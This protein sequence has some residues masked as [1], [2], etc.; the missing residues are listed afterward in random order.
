VKSERSDVYWV[1]GAAAAI[2]AGS[3]ALVGW[4]GAGGA[5]IAAIAL[6]AGAN[7]GFL[8]WIL[9]RAARLARARDDALLDADD[10]R[11]RLFL[12]TAIVDGTDDAIVSK[13]LNGMIR[14]WNKG[15]EK[16]F[17]FT[18]EEAVGRPIGIILPDDRA[19]EEI[20]IVDR[21]RRGERVEHFETV[22]RRKGGGLIDVTV[23]ISPVRDA[24]GAI[25]GASKIARDCSEPKRIYRE[26]V[27]TMGELKDIKAAL[28]EH[29]IVAI[30]DPSGRITYVNQKFCAI[31]KYSSGELV[32][33]DHRIINSGYHSKEFFRDLWS[34]IGH[35]KVWRGEVRNRAKD[36]TYYWVDTTI[37]PRV[38]GHGKPTQYIAIRTDITQRKANEAEIQRSAAEL[39]EKNKE[40]ETIVFTASHD[41]RSPLVN[42]QGFS[43]QLERACERIRTVLSEAGGG[44]VPTAE[45]SQPLNA[46]IPQALRFINAGVKKMDNLLSGLLRFSRLGRVSINVV[47]LEMTA[48][49]SEIIAAMRFQLNEAKADIKVDALPACLGDSVHTSQVFANL[50]DNALK[51]RDP[52]RP[53]QIRITGRI[54]GGEAIYSVADNGIGIAPEYHGKVFEIFHRLNPEAPGGEGLGLTIAQRVLERQRGK[55]WVESKEG[56]GSTFHVSL[57]LAGPKEAHA[58]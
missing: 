28:D 21:I 44:P 6:A 41:L 31:S 14:S 2:L 23:T 7:L 12:A 35:G 43:R 25:V 24:S 58:P 42:V 26:M 48:L 45:L 13:D 32:G 4:A 1:F 55:I 10:M 57:P 16:V 53:L 51:Y 9:A 36:G 3:L 19:E 20:R 29:S 30:T 40:L 27:S 50:I 38:D 15:A 33:Q 5:R 52:G 47:P 49:M 34:T 17:G 18:A 8:A 56:T 37:F 11:G 46:A 22:R 39:A 54:Q